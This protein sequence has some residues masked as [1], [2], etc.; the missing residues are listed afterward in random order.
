MQKIS[1]LKKLLHKKRFC[2]DFFSI[3][4]FKKNAFFV[5]N[6]TFCMSDYC[7]FVIKLLKIMDMS[8]NRIRTKEFKPDKNLSHTIQFTSPVQPWS[9][10][11]SYSNGMNGQKIR[12][13]GCWSQAKRC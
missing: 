11:Y 10:V 2:S 13:T 5:N 6:T 1:G 3:K 7:T 12:H 9:Q 4:C 8:S